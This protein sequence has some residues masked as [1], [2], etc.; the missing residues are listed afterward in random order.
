[1]AK[2]VGEIAVQ[3]GADVAPLQRG[4]GQARGS[5]KTFDRDVKQM[6]K[7]M[8]KVGA[9]I[10]AVTTGVVVGLAAMVKRQLDVV[11]ALAD[12]AAQA[13]TTVSAMQKLTFAGTQNAA[14]AEEVQRALIR[15]TSEMST[16]ASGGTSIAAKALDDVGIAALGM[17]GQLRSSSD[18]MLE[19]A[20]KMQGMAS[21]AD[22]TA[23][24]VNLFGER[25]GPRLMPMLRQGRDGIEQLGRKAD[26]LGLILDDVAVNKAAAVNAQFRAMAESIS[27][28]TTAAVVEHADELEALAN[29]MIDEG[30]PALIALGQ[31]FA[32]FAGMVG[33]AIGAVSRFGQT[34]ATALGI[35]RGP[36]AS[37]ERPLGDGDRE[38]GGGDPSSSGLFYVDEDG[39]VQ[40]YGNAPAIPG[41]TAPALPPAFQRRTAAGAG[42]TAGGGGRGGGGRG[43]ERDFEDE[44]E[45]L[46]E[47]F[48]TE[49]EILEAEYQKQ[50]DLL[51]EFRAKKV[52]TEEE[53]NQLEERMTQDHAEKL[54]AIERAAQQARLQAFT[55]ALG[56]LSSLMQSENKKLFKIGQAAAI[57]EATVSG[58]RAAVEAWEAGMAT[59]GPA[60]PAIAAAYAGASLAKTGML[61]QQI[62]GA[63]SSGGG[64]QSA[65]GGSG[66]A[67]TTTAAESQQNVQTLN[68]SVTNDPF[69]I[70]DRVVRQIVGA[71]N[72]SQRNGSTLIRATVT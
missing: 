58:L 30:L 71:I 6:A 70:S 44:M 52:A 2:V 45:K 37:G 5:V 49:N 14:S 33:D 22:K 53:F 7:N 35:D 9:T 64:G 8:V 19:V 60:A 47:Q 31:G 66:V 46:Q 29:F 63:S 48:A 27:M 17:D 25:L 39:N 16:L 11:E 57:A 4:M 21:D 15:L 59:G 65:G 10:A 38:P 54:A 62:K 23:L 32:D 41:I 67:S 72:E 3:V 24:A 51:A 12:T 42:R 36:G 20:E 34:V 69:G 26:D 28:K 40:E 43:R 68:F 13:N 18:V 56:D 55:G 50:T 61:I 1:M